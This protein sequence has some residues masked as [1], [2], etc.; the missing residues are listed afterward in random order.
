MQVDIIGLSIG[1]IIGALVSFYFYRKSLR[2]K[3][4]CWAVNS[5]NIIEGYS[6]KINDLR[7]L[8]KEEQ[9]EN[10]TISKI[11]FWNKGRET[12][13]RKDIETIN[14]LRIVGKKGVKFLDA[15]ILA[16]NNQ[17]SQSIV[18]ITNSGDCVNLYFEYLD[19]KQ[20]F[21]SQVVHTGTSSQDIQIIGDIMGVKSLQ[22]RMQTPKW[23]K[24]LRKSNFPSKLHRKRFTSFTIFF[25]II[26]IIFGVLS[27]VSPTI[28]FLNETSD[29]SEKIVRIALPIF[30]IIM[31]ILLSA[32]GE[33]LRRRNQIAPKGLEIFQEEIF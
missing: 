17:S 29:D 30:F 16:S 23:V 28:L 4:P 15:K 8:F 22:N 31:G 14:K 27:L 5:S 24:F 19:Q 7:I 12:I 20:G 21:V 11:L 18:K 9:I 25:G 3:E 10:L 1:V 26:N 32:M 2:I 6:S 13:E 33:F